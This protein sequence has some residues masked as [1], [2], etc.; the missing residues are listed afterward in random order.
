MTDSI[1]EPDS[2]QAR[3]LQAA[4]VTIGEKKVAGTRMRE[5]AR[6]AGMSQGH[7]HYYYP[8]KQGLFLALLDYMGTLFAEERQGWVA[9]PSLDP[10][11]KLAKFLTQEKGLILQRGDLMRARHDF[12]V[13]GTSD[14]K[15]AERIRALYS[16][17]RADISIVVAE[18]VKRGDFGQ[19]CAVTVP[20]LMIALMEGA[21]MQY[22]IDPESFDLDGYFDISHE[23]VLGL[24]CGPDAGDMEVAAESA[25]HE[26]GK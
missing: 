24:L 9:D 6:Q 1:P 8:A 12:A 18:W 13:Q 7:L 11:S 3:I 2:P 22:L 23:M 26:L 4:L 20:T 14:S 19:R 17:W 10:E 21:M 16:G 5:I 15:I 25:G